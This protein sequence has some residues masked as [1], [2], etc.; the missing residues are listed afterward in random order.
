MRLALL[1]STEKSET[2]EMAKF[3]EF[4]ANVRRSEI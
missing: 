3:A 2:V 4:I 1:N